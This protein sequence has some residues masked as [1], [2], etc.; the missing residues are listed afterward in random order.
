MSREKRY[1]SINAVLRRGGIAKG[2]IVGVTSSRIPMIEFECDKVL[3]CVSFLNNP[4]TAYSREV[5]ESCKVL[6]RLIEAYLELQ[7]V[8]AM[9]KYNLSERE[10]W[11]AFPRKRNGEY[12][13]PLMFNVGNKS[14]HVVGFIK[15]HLDKLGE[16]VSMLRALDCVDSRYLDM[17]ELK[18]QFTLRLS[19]KDRYGL[20]PVKPIVVA[21][22][23]EANTYR[24]VVDAKVHPRAYLL[25]D[26]WLYVFRKH[27]MDL[28]IR[29][30]R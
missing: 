19:G 11:K 7:F 20:K 25:A 10:I 29:Y 16:F 24:W 26:R 28:M 8:F 9:N 6:N 14:A 17:V 15:I 13:A 4:K 27:E 2:M 18:N 21:E 5:D 22:I 12:A 3:P 1:K 23:V 30:M